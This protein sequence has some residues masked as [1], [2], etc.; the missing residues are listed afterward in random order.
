[1]TSRQIA[2]IAKWS[3]PHTLTPEQRAAEEAAQAAPRPDVS[4]HNR[5]LTEEFMGA[6]EAHRKK[7]IVR[8]EMYCSSPL[9]PLPFPVSQK[10]HKVRV[11]EVALTQAQ[12]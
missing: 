4:G 9:F 5:E 10:R 12:S 2:A 3:F 11:R 8:E 1:M 7:W 6:L